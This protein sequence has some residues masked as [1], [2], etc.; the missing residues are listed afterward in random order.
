MCDKSSTS[1]VP[2]ESRAQTQTLKEKQKSN[3]NEVHF[4]LNFKLA[5]RRQ[6][7][8]CKSDSLLNWK[9]SMQIVQTLDEDVR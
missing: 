7:Q 3:V 6:W 1:A 4:D 9:S 8:K 2:S 5:F